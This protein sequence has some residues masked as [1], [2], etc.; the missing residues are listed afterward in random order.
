MGEGNSNPYEL[1]AFIAFL[2]PTIYL[3]DILMKRS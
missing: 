1:E 2:Y 3:K